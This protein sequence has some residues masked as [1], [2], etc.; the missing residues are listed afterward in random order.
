MIN[1]SEKEVNHFFCYVLIIIF[2]LKIISN[3][4]KNE[5]ENSKVTKKYLYKQLPN[6]LLN[7]VQSL[8]FNHIKEPSVTENVLK[9][10]ILIYKI[11]QH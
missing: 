10:L 4:N 5:K 6:F 9:T 11:M 7:I 1:Q 2:F 3:I 8:F